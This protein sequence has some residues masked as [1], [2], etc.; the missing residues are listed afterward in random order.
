M[1]KILKRY[2]IR[3]VAA[4]FVLGVVFF[5]FVILTNQLFRRSEMLLAYGLKLSVL[6]RL[7]C[8]LLPNILIF[9][10]PMAFLVALLIGFGRL[11]ADNEILAMRASGVSLGFVIR[12]ALGLSILLSALLLVMNWAVLPRINLHVVDTLYTLQFNAFTN[13]RPGRFYDEFETPNVDLTLYFSN[14]TIDAE[15]PAKYP[16]SNQTLGGIN[17]KV[18]ATSEKYLARRS[19]AGEGSQR[20]FRPATAG[21]SSGESDKQTIILTAATGKIEAITEDRAIRFTLNDGALQLLDRKRPDENVIIHFDKF[22]KYIQ[23]EIINSDSGQYIKS[24]KEMTVPELRSAMNDPGIKL[25]ERHRM[26]NE[27]YQRLSLP[28]SCV[29]FALLGIPL[30]IIIRPASKAYGFALSFILIM[31]YF[32]VLKWGTSLGEAGSTLAPL[33]IFSPNILLAVLGAALLYKAGRM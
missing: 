7:V 13:L 12:P 32:M 2:V 11:A 26:S 16:G 20:V 5:T 14:R 33:A 23:P 4:P 30:A 9:I 10:A 22:I 25:E 3:E 29:A 18:A 1:M 17:L 31:I 24:R 8:F 28:L 6:A 27:F 19:A 21:A 15:A